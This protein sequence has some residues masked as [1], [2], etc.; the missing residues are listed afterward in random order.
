MSGWSGPGRAYVRDRMSRGE[1]RLLVQMAPER[2]PLHMD[3][4]AIL[5][6]VSAP[7]DRQIV[8]LVLDRMTLGRP[9]IAPPG[10]PAERVALLRKA[11]RQ[12]VEDPD[13]RAEAEKQ[14]LAIDPTWGDGRRGRSSGASIGTPPNVVERTRAI[15]ALPGEQ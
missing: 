1:M 2:D 11:F 7:E 10:V 3:T 14:K 9:F 5:D 13:F 8:A 6:L 15:V 12:A 4:P